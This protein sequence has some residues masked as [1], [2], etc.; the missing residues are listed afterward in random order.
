MKKK[1]TSKSLKKA[2]NSFSIYRSDG[3]DYSHRYSSWD[4]CYKHFT[5]FFKKTKPNKSDIKLAGLHL[6][7]YLASWGMFRNPILL[8]SGIEQYELLAKKLHNLE[9][10]V[11]EKQYEEIEVFLRAL[12]KQVNKVLG[13][14]IKNEDPTDTLV[15]KIMLGVYSNTPAFDRFFKKTVSNSYLDKGRLVGSPKEKIQKI[16]NIPIKGKE[17]TVGGFIKS[18]N[19]SSAKEFSRKD[20]KTLDTIFFQ[21]GL[22]M[23]D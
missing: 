1:L 18:L 16:F 7:F 21:I 4:L 14:K 22:G 2:Y 8:N 9:K 3:I 5:K 12:K 6:G 10:E 11:F 17:K 23:P 13:K 15:T 19:K 20:M